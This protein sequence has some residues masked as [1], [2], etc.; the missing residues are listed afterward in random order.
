M[1]ILYN[2]RNYYNPE[3][4]AGYGG[5]VDPAIAL[6]GFLGAGE[7]LE[8]EPRYEKATAVILTFLANNYHNKTKL[9][10]ALEWEQK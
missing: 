10:P 5:P 2:F 3:C 8:S 7:T 9:G 6:G 1:Y 4:L